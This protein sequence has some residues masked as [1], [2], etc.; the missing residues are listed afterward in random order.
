[1]NILL[2]LA[3]LVWCLCG[4]FAVAI[5]PI[6]TRYWKTYVAI[7]VFG[8]MSLA[9]TLYLSYKQKVVRRANSGR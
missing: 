4:S 8:P 5:A 1:M 7:F 9:W 6:H 2:P 3:T